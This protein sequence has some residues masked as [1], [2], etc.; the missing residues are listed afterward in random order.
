MKKDCSKTEVLLSEW[1]RM[2]LSYTTSCYE[3]ELYKKNICANGT[4]IA[5][6]LGKANLEPNGFVDI[7][8]K[9]S[10]EHPEQTRAEKFFEMFPNAPK[11]KDGTPNICLI[12]LGWKKD[13]GCPDIS[14]FACWRSKYEEV[15]E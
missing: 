8:Q 2:C 7:I 10:D 15:A 9:W 11:G 1:A 12:N 3:C 4:Y 6:V 5:R 13:D 14:C